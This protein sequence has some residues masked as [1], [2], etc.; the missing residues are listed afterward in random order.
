MACPQPADIR[1]SGFCQALSPGAGSNRR[2]KGRY[3]TRGGCPNHCVAHAIAPSS[4]Q[5]TGNYGYTWDEL[6][7]PGPT[8]GLK[9]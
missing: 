2:P 8:V 6:L 7:L 1:L 9:A 5:E 4:L 3:R